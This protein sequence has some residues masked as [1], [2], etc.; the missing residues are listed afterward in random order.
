MNALRTFKKL[1]PSEA[2]L[3]EIMSAR[4]W[5]SI[6]ADTSGAGNAGSNNG[7]EIEWIDPFEWSDRGRGGWTSVAAAAILIAGV[8]GIAAVRSVS[9]HS[10]VVAPA[11]D[12]AESA[13]FVSSP[14]KTLPTTTNG[15]TTVVPPTTAPHD[16]PT[17]GMVLGGQVPSCSQI[18]TDTYRCVLPNP[19][20]ASMP[21]ALNEVGMT[22]YYLDDSGV[23]TGGCR[24]TTANSSEW[25]CY[26]GQRAVDE[27]II[28]GALLGT[29]Q[30]PG[31]VAG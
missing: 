12:P 20:D 19:F 29:R 23:V 26:V 3:D 10:V 18:A 25:L 15:P 24:T 16:L 4:V 11:A 30:P 1:R 28:S 2:E 13:S 7:H 14:N 21:D 17:G 6:L 31:F 9:G 5:E 8:G 27:D 22:E